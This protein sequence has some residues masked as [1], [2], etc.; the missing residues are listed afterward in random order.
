M[1]SCVSYWWRGA[2]FPIEK[3]AFLSTGLRTWTHTHTHTQTL[4]GKQWGAWESGRSDCF[5][6]YMGSLTMSSLKGQ[7]QN[8]VVF[9]NVEFVFKPFLC[10]Q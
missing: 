10:A 3:T 7:L 4:R 8:Y 6:W 5:H 9:H 1:L 2:N